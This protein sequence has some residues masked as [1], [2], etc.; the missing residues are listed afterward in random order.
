[1]SP[2]THCCEIVGQLPLN[3]QE[4]FVAALPPATQTPK[5]LP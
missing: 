1:M 2:G 5:A 3:A 4:P